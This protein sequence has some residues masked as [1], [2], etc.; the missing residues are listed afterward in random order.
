MSDEKEEKKII[1][2]KGEECIV[3]RSV[4]L[5]RI[6]RGMS[7]I[8]FYKMKCIKPNKL[9]PKKLPSKIFGAVHQK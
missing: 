5:F 2:S 1:N 4:Y 9:I 8:Q 6:V 3:D 7:E